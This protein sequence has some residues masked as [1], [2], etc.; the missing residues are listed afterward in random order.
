[1]I[2]CSLFAGGISSHA[3]GA[4]LEV[5]YGRSVRGGGGPGAT[6]VG[7]G[8]PGMLHRWTERRSIDVDGAVVIVQVTVEATKP[9]RWTTGRPLVR[10][11]PAG[12]TGLNAVSQPATE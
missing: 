5:S 9:V 3:D 12:V 10:R 6:G 2:L 7:M 8:A 11:R 4:A 1:M